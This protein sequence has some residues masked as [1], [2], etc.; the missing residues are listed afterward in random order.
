M[1]QSDHMECRCLPEPRPNCT[2]SDERL[3]RC[4]L[5]CFKL[6]LESRY[7][8]DPDQSPGARLRRRQLAPGHGALQPTATFAEVAPYHPV[9]DHGSRQAHAELVISRTLRPCQGYAD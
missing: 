6:A 8:T 3:V 9:I 2:R 5:G 4:I 1:H 7:P